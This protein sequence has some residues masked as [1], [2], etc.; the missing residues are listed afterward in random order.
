MDDKLGGKKVDRSR[1]F[2]NDGGAASDHDEQDFAAFEEMM[3]R[4]QLDQASP[5]PPLPVE[6]TTTQEDATSNDDVENGGGATADIPMFR[7][8]A[9]AGPVKVESL[10]SVVEY[11]QPKRPEVALEESDSEEHWS[12]LAAAAIDAQTIRA[13]ALVPLPA[14]QYPKRVMHI[15]MDKQQQSS[16][17]DPRRRSRRRKLDSGKLASKVKYV[18]VLSPYAGGML[19]GKMLADVVH[20]EE[21]AAS[22]AL[23]RAASTRGGRGG[24]RGGSSGFS[25]RGRGRGRGSS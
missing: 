25:G 20:E 17:N 3:R 15:S 22:A 10:S 4:K 23:R 16:G 18:R 24:G 9:G 14:M 1:L 8:F 5:P 7:L 13:V 19:R 12:A 6:V 11:T 2:D 21:E